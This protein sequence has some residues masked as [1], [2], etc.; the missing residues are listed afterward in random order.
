M[1][2]R[3]IERYPGSVSKFVSIST[4]HPRVWLRWSEQW[5]SR[6][7]IDDIDD[8]GD[9]DDIDDAADSSQARSHFVEKYS[10][11]PMALLLQVLAKKYKKKL[12]I[13][14]KSFEYDLFFFSLDFRSCLRWS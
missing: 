4:P 8:I 2:R 9:I 14:A 11:K 3:F 7:D 12:S 6:D 5:D 1:K 13:L 10:A